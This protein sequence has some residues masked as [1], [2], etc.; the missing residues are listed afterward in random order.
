MG[1]EERKPRPPVPEIPGVTKGVIEAQRELWASRHRLGFPE[2][3]ADYFII[4]KKALDYLTL[5]VLGIP[6]SQPEPREITTY[7]TWLPRV[8]PVDGAIYLAKWDKPLVLDPERFAV[9]GGKKFKQ[10]MQVGEISESSMVAW[11]IPGRYP[12]IADALEGAQK[13]ADYEGVGGPAQARVETFFVA[14]NSIS[15]I[16]LNEQVSQVRLEGLALQTEALLKQHGLLTARDTDW[17][18]IFS[19]T[20]RALTKDRRDRINPMVSRIL[21]RAA[22]L[23]VVHKE[24]QQRTARTKG[25]KLIFFLI[26]VQTEAVAQLESA[27]MALDNLGSFAYGRGA[28]AL[29]G[30]RKMDPRE[31]LPLKNAVRAL[32]KRTL[33]PIEVA[34]YAYSA[35]LAEAILIGKIG[36][37]RKRIEALEQFLK[38]GDRREVGRRSVVHY[39]MGLDAVSARQRMRQAFN[40]IHEGL[41]STRQA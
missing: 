8:N 29:K 22:Y 2:T 27:E 24:L 39:L 17:K 6:E 41:A 32:V 12:T 15:N 25:L 1:N 31:A 28:S 35:R 7:R 26:G 16:F 40:V 9:F 18:R 30:E 19:L 14:L 21:A 33:A 36:Q 23:R 38:K 3:R 37:S 13:I 10:G 11:L 34:P 5:P 20:L 4:D